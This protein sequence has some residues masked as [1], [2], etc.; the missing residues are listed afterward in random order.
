MNKN[1]TV[2]LPIHKFDQEVKELLPL[3][4]ESV[5]KNIEILLV[6]SEEVGKEIKT[7]LTLSKNVKIVTNEKTSFFDLVKRGVEDVKTS[8]FSILEFDDQY[9][10]IWFTNVEQ[11]IKD[12]PEVS[13]F[14][15]L[16]DIIDLNENKF[17]MF[18]NEAAW[19]SS[20][21]EEIGYVDFQSLENF[22]NFNLTGAVFNLDDFKSIGG[23]KTNIK[24][25]F[26][27][28]LLLRAT[29]MEK[30]VYVIPKVG[31]LHTV[32]KRNDALFSTYQKDMTEEESEFWFNTAKAEYY[33]KEERGV[34]YM[35]NAEA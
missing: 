7:E 16:T 18:A 13:I 25:T 32:G 28:E 3:S 30:L 15:P 31:Y 24:L 4:L 20:F 22:F 33:F 14:L 11:Y 17:V 8:Y 27:Y 6:T 21:S 23:L 9:T 29:Y 34:E 19:A 35:P 12:K 26:W 1:L 10:S 5:D 2:I